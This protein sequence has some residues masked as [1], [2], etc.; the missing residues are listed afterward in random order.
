MKLGVRNDCMVGETLKEKMITLRSLGYDFLELAFSREE[1]ERLD[2]EAMEMYKQLVVETGV[3]ICNTSIGEL[4][5]FYEKNETEKKAVLDAIRKIID[6]THHVGGNVI[7]LASKENS[8]QL[9][10][11]S[12]V[13]REGLKEVADYAL[14]KGVTLALEPVGRFRPSVLDALVR[15]INHPAAG[16]YYDMGNCLYGGEDPVE[17]AALSGD[18]K[19]VV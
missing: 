1:I 17:Q 10:T 19:S 3:P 14:E 5:F 7:L 8:N 4:L 6:L 12:A 13:Y 18:R 9:E 11:Y 2:M 16:L 15:E